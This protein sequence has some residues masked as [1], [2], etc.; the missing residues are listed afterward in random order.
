MWANKQCHLGW[1]Y[2]WFIDC[3]VAIRMHKLI[4]RLHRLTSVV[5]KNIPPWRLQSFVAWGSCKNVSFLLK[6]LIEFLSLM[7]EKIFC[8]YFMVDSTGLIMLAIWPVCE[9]PVW[10]LNIQSHILTQ[11]TVWRKFFCFTFSIFVLF[12]NLCYAILFS[13]N[14][15]SLVSLSANNFSS[16]LLTKSIHF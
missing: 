14:W 3:V 7:F 11:A 6:A 5:G 15:L 8:C 4:P 16:K 10:K 13:L 1:G 12:Q 9:L 2:F